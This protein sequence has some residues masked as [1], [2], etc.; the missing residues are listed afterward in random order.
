MPLLLA[1][2]QTFQEEGFL[3]GIL[4]SPHITFSNV[5]SRFRPV[6]QPCVPRGTHNYTRFHK[7]VNTFLQ[8][9]LNFFREIA[10]NST[11]SFIFAGIVGGSLRTRSKVRNELLGA[12]L[13]ELSTNGRLRGLRVYQQTLRWRTASLC[14]PLC[15]ASPPRG[16]QERVSLS[17]LRVH[18]LPSKYYTGGIII[19]TQNWKKLLSRSVEDADVI[20]KFRNIKRT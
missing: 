5:V 4:R 20:A 16:R 12:P 15:F 11:I 19:N 13:G 1:K 14:D 6:L 9:F 3:W 10:L 7:C 2:Q 8:K 18:R 17:I